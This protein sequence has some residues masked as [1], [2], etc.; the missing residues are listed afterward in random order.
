MAV[1]QSALQRELKQ[2]R[3][4]PSVD[5]EALIGILRTSVLL[6][7][8]LNAVVATAGLTLPQYNVLRILRGAGPDGLPTL[9]I[10]DRMLDASPGVTRLLDKLEAAGRVRRE[11]CSP[12]RRQVMCYIT[13]AGLDVLTQLD[14]PLLAYDRR[15]LDVLTDDEKEVLIS[16]L[17]RIRAAR[18]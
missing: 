11:R 13:T 8:E 18:D 12:D 3:P 14:P 17:D 16:L 7:R 4:F 1:T 6:E 5:A 2:S 9:A 10:R 15:A